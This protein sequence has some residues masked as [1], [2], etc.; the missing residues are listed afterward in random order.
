MIKDNSGIFSFDEKKTV[1]ILGHLFFIVLTWYSLEFFRE[2]MT[3]SDGAYYNFLLIET[4]KPVI[5]HNRW[6][7]YF[8][9]LLPLLAV[10]MSLPLATVLK[11]FSTSLILFQY[12]FFVIIVFILKDYRAA[13]ALLLSLCLTF[14]G[15]FYFPITELFMGFGAAILC[16]AVMKKMINE[17]RVLTKNILATVVLLLFV[18]LTLFHPAFMVV[19]VFLLLYEM[20]KGNY[21]NIHL[22]VLLVLGI[23]W[24]ITRAKIFPLSEYE[25]NK[26]PSLADLVYYI[27]EI[28]GF[29]STNY[30]L[31]L[32][33]DFWTSG[34]VILLAVYLWI[35]SRKILPVMVMLLFTFGWL[36]LILVID[37]NGNSPHMYEYYYTIFGI[38]IAL[39]FVDIVFHKIKPIIY[40]PL[41]TA[42]FA[43]NLIGIYNSGYI[44]RE[45]IKYFDRINNYVHQT[46]NSKGLLSMVNFPWGIGWATWAF[47]YETLLNSALPSPDS[48]V[49]AYVADNMARFDSIINDPQ[50][51]IGPDWCQFCSRTDKLN[52]NYFRIKPGSYF[53]INNNQALFGQLPDKLEGIELISHDEKVYSKSDTLIITYVKIVN[54]TGKV[55]PSMKND[56]MNIGLKYRI[57]DK[58]GNLVISEGTFTSLETDI[59]SSIIQGMEVGLPEEKGEYIVETDLVNADRN[60]WFGLNSR[61]SLI[62]K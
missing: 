49:T 54:N 12:F 28:E 6:S 25:A 62:V 37:R 4:G 18:L 21:S 44:Y 50:L 36:A 40:V 2:R 7:S 27:P 17:S 9:Q 52:Q 13:F 59:R 46:G 19:I 5:V 3:T 60:K 35:H 53:K 38:F 1:I 42:L 51:F 31:R 23:G 14:R 26:M 48:A 16:W 15:V 45:R 24:N 30:C 32:L 57:Y 29:K 41:L 10:K 8:V 20:S 11:V 58:K 55:I 22:W 61:F 56:T 33:P 34:I 43:I 47:P 39:P